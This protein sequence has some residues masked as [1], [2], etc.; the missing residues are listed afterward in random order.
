MFEGFRAQV[1][2]YRAR[3][4]PAELGTVQ[5]ID[6][7]YWNALSSGTRLPVKAV[8]NVRAGMVVYGNSTQ[9]FMHLAEALRTGAVF[10]ELILVGTVPGMPLGVMEGHA[11]LTGYFLAFEC[12][13]AELGVIVGYSP[14]MTDW[15]SY[16]E[17]G[18]RRDPY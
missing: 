2:W 12:I 4:R 7:S 13:P 1:S 14:A 15:S 18:V 17:P 10:P 3:I 9:S 5:Y 16:G 11:R 8:E 6:Y